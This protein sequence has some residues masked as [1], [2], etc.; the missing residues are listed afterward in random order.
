M[1]A[2]GAKPVPTHLKLL[3]GNPGKRAIKNDNPKGGADLFDAP[4]WMNDEQRASW[5]YAIAHAPKGVLKTTDRS[6]LAAFI[7]AE[8]AFIAATV[9]LDDAPQTIV[10]PSGRIAINPLIEVQQ[11]QASLMLRASNELGFTP[12]ARNRVH[13]DDN[14]SKKNA[15][16]DV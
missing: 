3:R 15:F 10:Q 7:V 14:D 13:V 12:A 5:A 9:A 6:T 4:A 8:Q 11:R 1:S 16:D 2:R